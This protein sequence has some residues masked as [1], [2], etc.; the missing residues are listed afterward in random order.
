MTL[1][2]PIWP[3]EAIPGLSACSARWE[4]LISNMLPA[5]LITAKA[6]FALP[7]RETEEPVTLIGVV[8][9]MFDTAATFACPYW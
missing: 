1:G 8:R 6:L 7:V 3:E 2:G 5:F 4:A 9:C